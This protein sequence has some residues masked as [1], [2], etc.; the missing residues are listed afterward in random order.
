MHGNENGQN[1]QYNPKG[2]QSWKSL[3]SDIKAYNNAKIKNMCFKETID[4]VLY[5]NSQTADSYVYNYLI[6]SKSYT[7]V[8]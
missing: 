3:I 2:Q 4:T 5:E 7:Q 8:L 6:H 1:N